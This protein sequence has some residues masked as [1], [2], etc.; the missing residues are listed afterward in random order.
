MPDQFSMTFIL[1]VFYIVFAG[2]IFFISIY[3]PTKLIGRVRYVRDNFPPEDYP[4]LYPSGYTGF[5]G[6]EGS[7][8]LVFYRFLN[9]AIAGIGLALL[10]SVAAAGYRPAPE[11][12]D[13]IFVMLYFFLQVIPWI[14]AA[15]K[16]YE[17]YRLMRGAFDAPKRQADLRPRYLFNFIAPGYVMVAVVLYFAWLIFYL[18]GDL[19]GRQNWEIYVTVATVTGLNILYA[20]IIARYLFGKKLDPYQAYKDQLKQI[21]ILTKILVFSSIGASLFH[22]LTLAA[23]RYEFEVFDPVLS[24]FYMQLCLA[25]AVGLTF[26][27]AKIEAVDFEV[28]RKDAAAT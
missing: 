2:Q 14:Y 25:V 12:G 1:A 11:G 5:A 15:V 6:R 20:V 26:S 3:Y 4:K 8:K 21:E 27:T 7:R 18:G 19:S 17:Q 9:Y 23:D 16:E 13:E 24:S 28:Y 10:L 22:I